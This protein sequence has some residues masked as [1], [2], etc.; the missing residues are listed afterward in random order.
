MG[1]SAILVVLLGSVAGDGLIEPGQPPADLGSLLLITDVSEPEVLVDGQSYGSSTSIDLRAGSH[2]LSVRSA[3]VG[4]TRV[5]VDIV[6]GELRTVRV[7]LRPGAGLAVAAGPVL[8]APERG[9]WRPRVALGLLGGATLALTVA[10]VETLVSNGDYAEFNRTPAAEPGLYCNKAL[11]GRGG[12]GCESL[13]SSA[14][15]ARN[16]SNVAL[17]SAPLLG[18]TAAVVYLTS[19]TSRDDRRLACAPTLAMVGVGCTGRF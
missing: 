6:A 15:R 19:R 3:G 9:S 11:P 8:P 10:V 2:Q 13:L 5:T 18:L 14:A 17:V 1:L 12:P 4:E 7:N 16:L